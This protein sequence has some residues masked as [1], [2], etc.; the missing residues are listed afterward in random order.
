V[1]PFGRGNLKEPHFMMVFEESRPEASPRPASR[2]SGKQLGYARREA[3]KL[4]QELA[5]T[6][7]HLQAVMGFLR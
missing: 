7:E 2:K 1:F 3:I 5:A 6:R 4:E